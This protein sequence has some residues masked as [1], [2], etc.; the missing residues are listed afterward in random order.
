[1]EE[2][3]DSTARSPTY[4]LEEYPIELQAKPYIQL[5]QQILDEK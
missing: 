4:A 2:A 1:M 3:R 5:Y